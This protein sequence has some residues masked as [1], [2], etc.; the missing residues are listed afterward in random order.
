MNFVLL[1]L[2]AACAAIVGLFI[3]SASAQIYT[4][5]A[6][7]AGGHTISSQSYYM[8]GMF[9]FVQDDGSI[10]IMRFDRDYWI[11]ADRNK[12]EY[13]Q[14]TFAELE[15]KMK[16]MGAQMD[17]AMQEMQRKLKSLPPEQRRQIEQLMGTK[18]PAKSAGGPLA[19]KKGGPSRTIAGLACT[20]YSVTE[21]GKEV[22]VLWT[23]RD[24]PEFTA[25]RKDYEKFA[26][27]MTAMRRSSGADTQVRAWAEAMKSVDGFPMESESAGVKTTVTKLE[28]KRTPAGEFEAP[29]GYRKVP[30][31][32]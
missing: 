22:L 12:K 19:V 25:M 20:R 28:R 1:R 18:L 16:D 30:A 26:R 17:A 8:P 7:V 5:S 15:A 2:F 3:G 31:P 4:E 24:V 10:V 9:K 29:A 11:G 32:F 13:W 21:D 14:M 23:A 27:S 6:T